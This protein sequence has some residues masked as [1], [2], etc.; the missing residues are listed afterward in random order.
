MSDPSLPP[1]TATGKQLGLFWFRT[2]GR[3]AEHPEM[4][5]SS[6]SATGSFVSALQITRRTDPHVVKSNVPKSSRSRGLPSA[7]LPPGRVGR[8]SSCSEESTPSPTFPPSRLQTRPRA[9]TV[10]DHR[11]VPVVVA[12]LDDE[13]DDGSVS[14]DD[15]RKHAASSTADALPSAAVAPTPAPVP[16]NGASG[17]RAEAAAASGGGGGTPVRKTRRGGR[18]RTKRQRIINGTETPSET[19]AGGV[20]P[21]TP[22]ESDRVFPW[23]VQSKPTQELETLVREFLAESAL[24]HEK[25]RSKNPVRA[26]QLRRIVCGVRETERD[27]RLR[28]VQLLVIATN[29]EPFGG[30][31]SRMHALAERAREAQV[32]VVWALTRKRLGAAVG[33]RRSVAVVA[34]GSTQNL[35]PLARRVIDMARAMPMLPVVESGPTKGEEKEEESEG[36][37]RGVAERLSADAPAFVPPAG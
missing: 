14:D 10:G 19:P 9:A 30:L 7:G 4:I 11:E 22:K 17:E 24:L 26:A 13:D 23:Y 35:E 34:V 18:R 20:G 15:D 12:E 1:M 36:G 3:A 29:V 6:D 28:S 31:Q 32:P 5:G 16:V 27:V 25:L 21:P 8:S 33:L 37:E 2:D